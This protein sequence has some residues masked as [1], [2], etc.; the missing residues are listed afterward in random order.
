MVSFLVQG[1]WQTRSRGSS[2]LEGVGGGRW[3][4]GGKGCSRVR[5]YLSYLAEE[6]ACKKPARGSWVKGMGYREI[7]RLSQMA[8]MYKTPWTRRGE[9]MPLEQG[10]SRQ[11][12]QPSE[13]RRGMECGRCEDGE[14]ATR[15]G[16]LHPFKI[17]AALARTAWGPTSSYMACSC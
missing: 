17:K 3:A 12:S 16:Y 15:W 11:L 9:G 8:R 2:W 4:C 7:G 10:S 1:K 14:E 6:K 5:K 13:R